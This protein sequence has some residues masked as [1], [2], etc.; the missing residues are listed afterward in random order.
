MPLSEGL[1][2]EEARW[3]AQGALAGLPDKEIARIAGWRRGDDS[4]DVQRVRR[5]IR[6]YE[7]F[8]G[9]DKG[10]VFAARKV[11]RT[12]A[13]TIADLPVNASR[14]GERLATIRN[15]AVRA[16]WDAA[17]PDAVV[18]GGDCPCDMCNPF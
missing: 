1:Q 12:A 15:L 5:T 4:P 17:A 3:A 9:A 13:T 2:L 18:H 16:I 14:Y 7:H 10:S 11:T 6:Q 8:I